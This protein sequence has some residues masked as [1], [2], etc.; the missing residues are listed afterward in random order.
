MGIQYKQKC[1]K[2]KKNYMLVSRRQDYV[3]C[4]D[5]QKDEL[6]TPIENE[7][8]KSF[9]DLPEEYYIENAFLRSVKIN[10]IRYGR[11]TEKQEMAF[12]KT[13]DKMKEEKQA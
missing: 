2:C 13:L 11:I 3:V 5:C 9:F 1:N 6:H 7:E 8:M 12:K 10:Y 4:Y